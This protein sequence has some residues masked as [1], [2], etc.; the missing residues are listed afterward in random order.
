MLHTRCFSSLIE[1][2][3]FINETQV[4]M[5]DNSNFIINP[6]FTNMYIQRVLN[7]KPSLSQ[8]LPIYIYISL[9]HDYIFNLISYFL[10]GTSIMYANFI[11]MHI[12]TYITLL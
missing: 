5:Y 7:K 8:G 6:L 2:I 3:A 12:M 11:V 4:F 10:M 9:S 1:V